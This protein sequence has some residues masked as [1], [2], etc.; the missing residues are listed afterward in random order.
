MDSPSDR[1][2]M[3]MEQRRLELDLAWKDVAAS[4]KISVATLGAIRRGASRPSALTKRRLEGA[5]Q[6]KHGSIATILSGGEPTPADHRS[7]PEINRD[8]V[9]QVATI[10]AD[11]KRL[12]RFERICNDPERVIMLDKFM[13]S[14][15]PQAD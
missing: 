15:D 11:R 4:A 7:T 3:A 10:T 8:I 12:E 1:L 5:L 2:A 13:E 6:W 14:I 9:D